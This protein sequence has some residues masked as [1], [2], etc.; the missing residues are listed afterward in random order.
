MVRLD[1]YR[2]SDFTIDDIE[3]SFQLDPAATRVQ[4]RYHVRRTTDEIC[5]LVLDGEGL[6]LERIAL[7]G[8][9]LGEQAYSSEQHRLMITAPPAEFE[10]EIDTVI[11]PERN[12]SLEGLYYSNQRF[13]TQCES[14]GFRH[15]AFSLDRPDVLSRFTVRIEADRKRY[16]TLLSNG[17]QT[18]AGA[19]EDGRHFTV[20]HDPY[21]KP[22]Y[23]FALVAGAFDTLED[24]FSTAS[25]TKVSLAIHTDHGDAQRATFAMDALK[26]SMRWDEQVFQREY[27]LSAFHIVAVR[28]F[29]FGAMENKGL[30]IFNSARLLADFETATDEDFEDVER[31]VAHEYFHNWTGNRI[32]L[33][34]WFQLCLKEGL[35]IYRDQEFSADQRSRPVRRIKEVQVLWA[36]QF[37]EDSGPLAHPVRPEQ[38]VEI[39][40]FYT[41][42]IYRKGA[43]LVRVLRSIVGPEAFNSAMQLYFQ[44]WDGHA[45]TVENFVECFLE[46]RDREK[47]FFRWYTQAGTPRL[48]AEG[49]FDAA[50]QSYSLRVSQSI[51]PTPGQTEKYAVPIPLS[52]GMI[53]RDGGEM[54]VRLRGEDLPRREFHLVLETDAA[55]F[56]FDDV[57]APPIPAILR[58]YSAP[59]LLADGLG[60]RELLVQMSSDPDAFTRWHAGQRLITAAIFSEAQ[61]DRHNGPSVAEI[62]SALLRELKRPAADRAFMAMAL[63]VPALG[64]LIQRGEVPDLDGLCEACNRVRR[65]LADFLQEPL[66]SLVKQ[67]D[68]R[69]VSTNPGQVADRAVKNAALKLLACLGSSHAPTVMGAFQEAKTMTQTMGALEALSEIGGAWFVDALGIFLDRW[70]DQPLVIDKWFAVQATAPRDDAAARVQELAA[71]PL[72]TLRNPN[73]VRS[74]YDMFASANL[75]AFHAADGS[76]YELI[77]QGIRKVDAVNPVVAARLATAFENCRRFDA[78]RQAKAHAVLGALLREPLSKNVE[79]VVRRVLG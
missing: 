22:T 65:A 30:N 11:S 21:P 5:P 73:R 2:P 25:G 79:D 26:R 20:W 6:T 55:T 15:I 69:P 8:Q 28:D 71:H 76:G 57:K 39:L 61:G 70:R 9:P 17:N 16:P 40:N 31:V 48:L 18:E 1:A 63:R 27:D 36:R 67:S 64:E 60:F 44:R 3:L 52:V 23:L 43:E 74:L 75:R 33:R 4:A 59:V 19:T 77:S 12:T 50:T 13:C 38:Y 54:H 24:E 46:D 41:A 78:G 14:E 62:A 58:D 49:Q 45:V 66:H 56:V 10:L 7:D 37:A 68:A 42:T 47:R 72:F 34:D 53:D 51:P 29:N 35:T 32:T